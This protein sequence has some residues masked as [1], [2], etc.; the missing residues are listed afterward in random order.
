[1]GEKTGDFRKAWR[2]SKEE[3]EVVGA[4]GNALFVLS[5]W[6]KEFIPALK[7]ECLIVGFGLI[8]MSLCLTDVVITSGLT[9]SLSYLP[10]NL[11]VIAPGLLGGIGLV[12]AALM[13]K[14]VPREEM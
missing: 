14:P 6:F 8:A 10:L 12:I 7:V 9:G 11:G 1:M 5:S 2:S 4:M 13:M 3:W